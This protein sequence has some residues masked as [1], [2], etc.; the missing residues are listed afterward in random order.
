MLATD[1]TAVVIDVRAADDYR[2]ATLSHARHL[3]RSGVPEGKDVGEVK[4]AKDDGRL[5][6][7]DHNPRIIVVGANA[8]DARYVAEALTREAFHNVSYYAGTFDE[9]RTAVKR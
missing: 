4:R 8:A 1:A 7:E 2:A 3:P 5:P 9:A 6:M